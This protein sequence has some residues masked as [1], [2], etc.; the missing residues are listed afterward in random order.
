[1]AQ[2]AMFLFII[3]NIHLVIS[4]DIVCDFLMLDVFNNNQ[5]KVYS[6]NGKIK[7]DDNDPSTHITGVHNPNQNDEDVKGLQI[8][9]QSL[10]YLFKNIDTKFPNLEQ[11]NLSFNKITRLANDDLVPHRNLQYFMI[12]ANLITEL[13]QNL[14]DK[15]QNL[16]EFHFV[17]N[18][19]L[20]VQHDIKLPTTI[21]YNFQNNT[22]IGADKE[23][24]A[25]NSEQVA[26][27][28]HLFLT[29]CPPTISQIEKSIET[30]ENLLNYLKNRN[31]LLKDRLRFLEEQNH[32]ILG[33][34]SS[35]LNYE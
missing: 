11:I 10:T 14:F 34:L 16:K 2:H 7:L 33:A 3:L 4:H 32:K 15:L 6:C 19:L 8:T 1:M 21:F 26:T 35:Q 13:N 25:N 29:D 20:H 12:N 27:L 24:Q 5:N 30:R 22:C 31:Q 28:K 9:E 18:R 23:A 17:E